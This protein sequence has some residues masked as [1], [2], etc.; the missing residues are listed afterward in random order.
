M[1]AN[2]A[3][4]AQRYLRGLA[5]DVA[6][7]IRGI[8]GNPSL[9]FS[10]ISQVVEVSPG[11]AYTVSIPYKGS[12]YT[13][14]YDGTSIILEGESRSTNIEIHTFSLIATSSS[15]EIRFG[16]KEGK[17]V[18]IYPPQIENRAFATS[19][20][21][22][23]REKSILSFPATKLDKNSGGILVSL[24]PLHPYES[25]LLPIFYYNSGFNLNYEDGAFVLTYGGQTLS[26]PY[27]ISSTEYQDVIV[28]WI[29]GSQIKL[30]V[31]DGSGETSDLLGIVTQEILDSDI[32]LIGSNDTVTGN[33][34]LDRFIVYSGETS[35]ENMKTY[36]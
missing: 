18:T 1:I 28:T 5:T 27:T 9:T 11:N 15:I 17:E 24:K 16:T 7:T 23:T 6:Q 26:V 19:I 33:M 8:V 21:E 10:Y 32:I 29:N 34:V 25:G 31:F 13:Q 4:Q 2:Y 12:L 3:S 30:S 36:R 20:T 14:I 35:I 22:T